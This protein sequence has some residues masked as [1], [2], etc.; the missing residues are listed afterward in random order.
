MNW[1][2][3]QLLAINP[4]AKRLAPPDLQLKWVDKFMYLGV[5]VSRDAA[6]FIPFNLDP[7]VHGVK[8]KLKA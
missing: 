8:A 3:S 6:S 2:K 7:V 5:R 4:D 1:S